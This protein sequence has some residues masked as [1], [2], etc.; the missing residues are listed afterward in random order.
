[1]K[2]AV[3][4]AAHQ[5][6][7]EWLDECIGS[8]AASAAQTDVTLDLRI[9]A[10]GCQQTATYLDDLITPYWWS[11][12]NVGPYVLR[13]SLV[14]LRPAEA[15]IIFDA[16]DVMLPE[17]F[18]VVL[19]KLRG[20]PLVGPSRTECT[21]DLTPVKF[22]AYRHG[23]CAFRADVLD[24]VGGYRAERIGADVDFIARVRQARLPVHITH[25]PL[26]LRRRHPASLT[27]ATETGFGSQARR[28]ARKRMQRLTESGRQ[29]YVRPTTVPLER[30][31]AEVVA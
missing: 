24:R 1:M 16:D 19:R 23:V 15:F 17:Y 5:V 28:E 18:P 20:Y 2:V 29:V 11:P 14:A 10:D 7:P 13:N 21:E 6:R 22:G 27:K 25:E 31:G 26:Y 3:I 9:G 4:V 12:V 30:R 8:I